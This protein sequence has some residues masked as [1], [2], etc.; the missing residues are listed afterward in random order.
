MKTLEEAQALID[1]LFE[2][3]T[4]SGS[5][6]EQA[7][8]HSENNARIIAGLAQ[9]TEEIKKVVKMVKNI[10]GQTNM[11]ALNASIE[12]AGAGEAGKGFAVVANEVKELAK[13]TA[14]ATGMISQKVDEIERN[15]ARASEASRELK[16]K[17]AGI[18]AMQQDLLLVVPA[19]E[20]N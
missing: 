18:H 9:A 6:L 1:E 2:R 5:E 13:Q 4:E 16:D 12:A 7:N 3:L 8:Q 19:S 15:A 17:I 11:L 10:A 14:E 20:E